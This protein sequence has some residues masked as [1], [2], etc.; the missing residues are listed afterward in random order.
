ML[1]R[2]YLRFRQPKVF[3]I[4]LMVFIIT[5]LI[6]HFTRGYDSDFGS[7]NL[8]LSVEAS[9]ASAVLTVAAEES[10]YLLREIL[11]IVKLVYE[12]VK[13][14]KEQGLTIEKILK[15]VLL[16]AEAQREVLTDHSTILRTMRENDRLIIELLK[17]KQ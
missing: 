5:S 11:A 3:L 12:L 8:T 9:V 4:A 13:L 17:E 14:V 7:T 15:G 6:L 16:I 1:K 10:L 2:L